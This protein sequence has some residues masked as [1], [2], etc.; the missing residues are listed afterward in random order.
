[1]KSGEEVLILGDGRVQR[2]VLSFLTCEVVWFASGRPLFEKE[3]N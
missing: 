2:E 1:M 3:G